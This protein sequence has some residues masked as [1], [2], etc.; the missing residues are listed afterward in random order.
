MKDNK[1]YE[2]LDLIE[3]ITKVDKMIDIHRGSSETTIM[4]EQYQHQ[5]LKLSAYLF[6]ELI[7]HSGDKTGVMYLIKIFIDKFYS[8][9]IKNRKIVK[10]E[11]L[12]R[13]EDL[14]LKKIS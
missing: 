2:I 8:K 11:Q 5:K 4:L 14:L 13:I 3:E 6:K 10:D 7:S 9:E 12:E 1:L